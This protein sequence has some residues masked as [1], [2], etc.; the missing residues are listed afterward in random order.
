MLNRSA[1]CA[2]LEQRHR[3]MPRIEALPFAEDVETPLGFPDAPGPDG[4]RVGHVDRLV[5][6]AES[7]DV[8][9][10]RAVIGWTGCW[11]IPFSSWNGR[12]SA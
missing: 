10:E 12:R 9:G 11:L 1:S 2:V 4:F 7:G 6:L 8:L 3:Q 5:P